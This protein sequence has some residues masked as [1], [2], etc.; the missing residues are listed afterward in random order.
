[1]RTDS[2]S[3]GRRTSFLIELIDGIAVDQRREISPCGRSKV[4]SPCKSQAH[5]ELV[6]GVP[7]GE[8]E[9]HRELVRGVPTGEGEAHRELVRGVP[10]GEGEAHRER[11]KPAYRARLGR[12]RKSYRDEVIAPLQLLKEMK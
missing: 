5:R 1:L 10:T 11:G 2:D 4:G 7:T 12:T 6:R 3:D 8:G 9:A